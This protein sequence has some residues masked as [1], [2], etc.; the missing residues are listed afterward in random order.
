MKRALIAGLSIIILSLTNQS[1]AH[2]TLYSNDPNACEHVAGQW[3]GTGTASNWF[4]GECAYHGSGSI[5]PL[6]DTNKFTVDLSVDK[7]SGSFLCPGHVHKV[8]SGT[9]LNGTVTLNTEYG[10]LTGIFSQESG[11]AN[12]TLTVS[13]GINATISIQFQRAL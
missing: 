5:S 11:E 3:V 10:D 2:S 12:G 8:I 6:D 7:N 13:P 9:C 4:L 1:Y